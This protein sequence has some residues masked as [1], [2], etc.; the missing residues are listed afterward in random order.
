MSRRAIAIIS[1]LLTGCT[2]GPNYQPPEREVPA[3]WIGT[4][5]TTAPTTQGS[6]TLPNPTD[7]SQWWQ[8]FNDPTLDSL[9][10]RAIQTNL[11]LRAAESRVRQAR[12]SY[13]FARG[14]HY[15]TFDV[16]ASYRVA[17][18][19]GTSRSIV[20][21]GGTV[22]SSTGGTRELYEAGLDAAW[23]IDIFG[24]IRREVEAARAN[25]Q[26]TIEDHRDVLITLTSELA[27]NYIDLRGTQRQLAIARENLRTQEYSADLT[28][29]RQ[30]GGFVSALD[31]ANADAQVAATKSQLPTLEQVAQQTIYNIALL[32]GAEPATLLN[33]LAPPGEIP[34]T[35]SEIPIGLP[36]ELL[37]RRPDIRRAEANLHTATARVGVATA[38]LF[39][40][41]ALTGSVGV[42]GDNGG[43]LF[44]WNNGVWSFGPSVT[45]PLFSAGR[46]R[47]NIA[48]QNELQEQAAIGYEQAVLTAL[49]D[50]ESALVAYA[51]EQQHRAALIDAVEAN[52]KAVDLSTRLYTQGQTDFLN[53]LSAQR[54]L[55]VSEDA[56]V[57]SDVT[58]ATNLVALYKALGG[59]WE[60]E[61]AEAT[62]R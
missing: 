2:V 48:V 20:T 21:S 60:S 6:Q 43:A 51:R 22:T 52:R 12:A 40:R 17:G 50:V 15:P 32:L 19:E 28:R 18:S 27:L 5:P 34:P 44:N 11:D 25:V 46:I 47:A 57:R 3:A 24:G 26:F 56:L 38:D 36:S 49:R 33:E 31:V 30:R 42:S 23:E 59:G 29:R 7:V 41:F 45:Y 61:A 8:T 54:S 13:R 39:P 14:G 62:G 1:C 9:I 10:D 35:P 53:V 37:R 55:Y 58:V 4:T 16:G